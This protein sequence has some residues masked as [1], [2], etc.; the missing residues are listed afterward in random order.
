MEQDLLHPKE[1]AKRLG[2]S[3]ST[4][5]RL[6]RAGDLKTVSVGTNPDFPRLRIRPEDLEAF[7][8]ER[9]NVA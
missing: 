3:L 7:I 2:V 8:Q 9:A 4:V 1:A 6:I 5:W